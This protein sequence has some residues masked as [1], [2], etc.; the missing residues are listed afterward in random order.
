MVLYIVVG[1]NGKIIANSTTDHKKDDR[2][3]VEELTRNIK[4][5][6][7]LGDPGYDGKNIQ[8]VAQKG[9]SFARQII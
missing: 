3:Q 7:V 2:S 6:E 8:D 5:K 4:T 1:D 9:V